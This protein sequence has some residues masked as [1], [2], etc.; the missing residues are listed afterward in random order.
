MSK[1]GMIGLG[2]M[3]SA[4]VRRLLAAGREVVGYNRT[5]AK[6]EP[7]IAQGMHY[8]STPFEVIEQCEIT[9]SMVTDDA[10][11]AA[12]TEG[13]TGVLAA[14][15]AGKIFADMST[16]SPAAV[17]ALAAKIAQ[18]GGVLLDA[19]VSGSQ[20]TVD[21]GKLLIMVGGDEAAFE[22]A[23]P[24]FL[25]IGPKVRRIGAVG[26]GKVMKIAIN[27][28]LA[29]QM[30]AMSEGVLLA[31]KSGISRE[32]A[33]E[34]VFGSA[35]CSPM[36]G[37]RGPFVLE[38]PQKAWFDVNMQQKDMKLAL[39]LGRQV[40]VPLPTTAIAN[41][42]LTAARAAGYGDF[43]FAV[44]FHTLAKMAGVEASPAHA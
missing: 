26:Q 38:M 18:T 4:M 25:D 36:M 12:V 39:E 1:V 6:A 20:L 16:I 37:Y 24:I 30:L 35:V 31:E 15:Q 13:P 41:E 43:D 42:W 17:R 40:D 2:E 11:I 32:L 28:Q 8:V 19:P 34:M 27:L 33:C 5:R 9:C 22:R 44:L 23:K 29:V 7:L 10:A 14:M 3:G 21:Q